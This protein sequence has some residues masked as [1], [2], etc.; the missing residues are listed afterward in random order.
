[1]H[2]V[3]KSTIL[4]V[5]FV[6]TLVEKY[7][8][9]CAFRVKNNNFYMHFVQKMYIFYAFRGHP[10]AQLL[11]SMGSSCQNLLCLMCLSRQKLQFLC[12]FVNT[13]VQKSYFYVHLV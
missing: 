4:N 2:F 3:S 1:M 6:D 5:H 7:Y 11:F 8:F 13:L 12:E 10:S 9:R